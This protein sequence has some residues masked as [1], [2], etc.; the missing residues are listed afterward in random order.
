MAMRDF[1]RRLI[2]AAALACTAGVSAYTH[3]PEAEVRDTHPE[4]SCEEMYELGGRYMVRQKPDSAL[5]VYRQLGDRYSPGMKREDKKHC[6]TGLSNAGFLYLY[7]HH[8][9]ALAYYYLSRALEI[10][11]EDNLDEAMPYVCLNMGLLYDDFSTTAPSDKWRPVAF[12]MYRRSF[13]MSLKMKDWNHLV[14][15]FID[16]CAVYASPLGGT[17]PE[18]KKMI[19]KEMR[20][21]LDQFVAAP[22]PPKTTDLAYGL[23]L[24]KT[25]KAMLAQ[26]WDTAIAT[27]KSHTIGFDDQFVGKYLRCQAYDFIS[28]NYDL[29]GKT[30]SAVVYQ[31]RILDLVKDD[32]LSEVSV[33]SSLRLSRLL[34]KQGLHEEADRWL[35]RYYERRD[36]LLDRDGRDS[37]GEIFFQYKFNREN[38]RLRESQYE[39]SVQRVITV[40]LWVVLSVGFAFILV[41]LYKNKKLHAKNESLYAKSLE[42]A[43]AGS[44]GAIASPAEKYAS[45][46]LDDAT[47]EMLLR[48]IREVLA[49]SGHICS[50]E[51]GIRPLAEAVKSNSTY[52]SQVVNEA[53]G[54]NFSSLLSS[55]RVKEAVR[56]ISE[57]HGKYENY[58]VQAIA[59]DV[60][61]KSRSSFS[62]AFKAETGL[63][64]SEFIKI[65]RTEGK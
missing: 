62:A 56:R 17:S 65:A 54:V 36:S 51:F 2:L 35:L 3:K 25:V 63:S 20:G 9:R 18:D 23:V 43:N 34:D 59:E 8:S 22:V 14:K 52:V 38:E 61:F 4:L 45:S 32:D 11:E 64:P 21:V 12:Q 15:A 6:V 30:D 60:G 39:V 50:P 26:D 53:Y 7:L 24:A 47:R 46:S 31:R 29:S 48:K 13:D 10:S 27:L 41:V 28:Y 42:L 37:P 33:Y 57:N 1:I 49:D 16:I 44:V 5:E 19:E 58:T 40:C 55:L